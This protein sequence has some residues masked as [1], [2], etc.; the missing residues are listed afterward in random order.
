[1]LR[2]YYLCL[3]HCGASVSGTLQYYFCIAM[4]IVVVLMFVGSFFGNNFSLSNLQP[5]ASKELGWFNSIIMIVAIAPWAYVGFD[6]IPQTAEEFNFSPNKTFK[7]IVYSLLAAA[8]TYVIMIL[9]TGWLGTNNANFNGNLWL[10]GAETQTAFGYI[11][12]EY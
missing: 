2:Y 7:L 8:L 10:T 3:L 4:V 1:M 5:L 6:N 11:G 9:Y 12:L